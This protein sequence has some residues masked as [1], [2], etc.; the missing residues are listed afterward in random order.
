MQVAARPARAP[1]MPTPTPISL[2]EQLTDGRKCLYDGLTL[3]F[4]LLE[5][6]R[7]D[8]PYFPLKWKMGI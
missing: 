2:Y 7:S 3:K 1:L 8:T 5:E 6:G 4:P